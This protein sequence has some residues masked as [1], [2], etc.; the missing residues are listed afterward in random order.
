MGRGVPNLLGRFGE[1][2]PGGREAERF[3]GEAAYALA[4][5]GELRGA[6]G[7]NH[8]REARVLDPPQLVRRDRFDLRHDNVGALHLHERAQ[9]GRVRHVDDVE[10]VREVVPRR[11]GVA[12]HGNHLHAQALEGDD[13]LFPELPGA[14]EHHFGRRLGEGGSDAHGDLW[15]SWAVGSAER[16][17]VVSG[18]QATEGAGCLTPRRRSVP[19]PG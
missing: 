1:L 13:D 6:G 9:G 3:R 8:R 11:V 12:V 7:G 4:I 14:Q 16:R 18:T 5:H 19:W 15:V 2:I 10:A 17:P